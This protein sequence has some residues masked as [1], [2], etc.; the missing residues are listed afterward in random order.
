[1][2]KWTFLRIP[3]PFAEINLLLHRFKDYIF[4]KYKY[5]NPSVNVLNWFQK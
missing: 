4:Q 1:M 2:E 5:R 3:P